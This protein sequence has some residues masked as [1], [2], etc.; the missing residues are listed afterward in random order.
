MTGL[1]LQD[2]LPKLLSFPQSKSR[3]NF[4]H[5][6]ERLDLE[7]RDEVQRLIAPHGSTLIV[8]LILHARLVGTGQRLDTT[9]VGIRDALIRRQAPIGKLPEMLDACHGSVKAAADRHTVRK[10]MRT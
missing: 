9:T 2:A 7:S 3:F 5:S 1:F 6:A 4:Q 10:G 8:F